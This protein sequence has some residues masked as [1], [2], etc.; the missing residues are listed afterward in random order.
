VHN[1]STSFILGYHGCDRETGERLLNNEAFRPSENS[2]DWLGSGV[3][4]WETNPD[5]ALDWARQRA[6]RLKRT[7][8]IEAEPFVIGAVIDPGFCLDLISSNGLQAV[9]QAYSD[10]RA[11]V[12]ASGAQIPENL[13]GDDL[14]QRK[15]D[16]AVINFLHA[17]R[18]SA[19][20]SPFDTVRGV[21]TEGEHLY[22]NSGFRR[23]THIQVCVRNL[24]NIH[25]VF[26]VADRYFSQP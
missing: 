3:Y 13:G 25:G 15:L 16:C 6:E 4:F 2:Y 21:F 5:R 18:Q 20:E 11:V 26:R 10:F 23:K 7:S 22:A 9:E 24:D 12:S 14:L 1:L 19:K 8:G 17:A